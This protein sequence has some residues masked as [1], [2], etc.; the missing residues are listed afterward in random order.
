M[1]L[2]YYLVFQHQ[3]FQCCSFLICEVGY[4]RRFWRDTDF[5][6]CTWCV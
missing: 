4:T 6:W 5:M 3:G 1:E 2:D